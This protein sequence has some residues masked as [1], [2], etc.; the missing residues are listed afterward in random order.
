MD[1][2]ERSFDAVRTHTEKSAPRR[3]WR[4]PFANL[5]GLN[6]WLG[7]AGGVEWTW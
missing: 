3:D 6:I 7:A 2:D 4:D 1:A 5:F